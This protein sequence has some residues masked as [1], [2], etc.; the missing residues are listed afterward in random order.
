MDV[1]PLILIVE[2][3]D[4]L[5]YVVVRQLRKLG[6]PAHYAVNGREAL[7]MVKE[8]SYSLISM[9]IMMPAMDGFEATAQIRLFEQ[10]QGQEHTPIIALTAYQDKA[11]CAEAGMDDYLF[12]P[13][14]MDELKKKLSEWLPLNG[15]ESLP[16]AL[17]KHDERADF[18]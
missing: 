11:R 5:R 15:S 6:Y 10:Q 17:D 1:I 16:K 7:R 12:K 4:T 13:V 3:D 8:H 2:D 18:L 9:D 14:T